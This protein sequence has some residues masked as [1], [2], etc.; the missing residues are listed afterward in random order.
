MGANM[1]IGEDLIWLWCKYSVYYLL[2]VEGD[3]HA[4]WLDTMMIQK[5][6]LK[7]DMYVPI[8]VP[9]PLSLITPLQRTKCW[10]YN[11]KNWPPCPHQAPILGTLSDIIKSNENEVTPLPLQI[12]TR[13]K[14]ERKGLAALGIGHP[15]AQDAR[16][17]FGEDNTKSISK[18]AL[19]LCLKAGEDHHYHPKYWNQVCL[20]QW[21]ALTDEEREPF[22]QHAKQ[23]KEAH[24][25]QP[26]QAQIHYNQDIFCE[27]LCH[28]F[29]S[30]AGFGHG[31]IGHA[32]FH[33][34][35]AYMGWGTFL[36]PNYHS[37]AQESE[38]QTGS[39]LIVPQTLS[40]DKDTHGAPMLPPLV[41]DE[42]LA[43]VL[44]AYLE[45]NWKYH[46]SGDSAITRLPW[47]L[48]AQQPS[49]FLLHICIQDGLILKNPGEMIIPE[50]CIW[51]NHL[52]CAQ[53]DLIEDEE[54]QK[55]FHKKSSLLVPPAITSILPSSAPVNI[56]VPPLSDLA[57]GEG[58][59]ISTKPQSSHECNATADMDHTPMKR[60]TRA[61]TAAKLQDV[62]GHH[63]E[64]VVSSDIVKLQKRG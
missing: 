17:L 59:P 38:S 19:L 35:V 63:E 10:F 33:V 23:L 46:W 40:L 45:E 64:G 43:K 22:N 11:K 36:K 3:T 30:F 5:Q 26:C 31:Q 61:G 44:T 62:D 28:N 6:Q 21:E 4:T 27:A 41:R 13:S 39:V 60:C 49:K 16:A 1:F 9:Y 32:A 8:L 14:L 2:P 52:Q 7:S 34:K 55:L 12:V 15:P 54:P 50:L 58:R 18:D 24:T 29:E 37:Q 20:C 57:K 47:Q 53:E 48:F 56:S 42:E 51:F 25:K